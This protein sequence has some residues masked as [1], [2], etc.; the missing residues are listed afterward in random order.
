[1]P[2]N[3]PTVLAT[4]SEELPA[5]RLALLL[6]HTEALTPLSADATALRDAGLYIVLECQAPVFL[7]AQ[8]QEGHIQIQADVP[9]E[10]ATAKGFVGLLVTLFDGKAEDELA[11]APADLV[12]A[13][14]LDEVVGLQRRRGLR[15]IYAQLK[16]CLR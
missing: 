14:G 6:D 15:G 2:S 16:E 5:E 9:G 7:F 3:L 1:M 10:A 13:L 8:V 4:F 11:G 12:A